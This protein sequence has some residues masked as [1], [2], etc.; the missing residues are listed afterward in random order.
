M[1]KVGEDQ[2]TGTPKVSTGGA[3]LA[4]THGNYNVPHVR[5]FFWVQEGRQLLPSGHRVPILVS[6]P[7]TPLVPS[8]HLLVGL[9]VL[10][11]MKFFTWERGELG[12]LRLH[13]GNTRRLRKRTKSSNLG[14]KGEW[15]VKAGGPPPN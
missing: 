9:R 6:H 10:H 7:E 1:G 13:G 2:V 5:E 4:L 12:E 8:H 14:G 15:R 11:V 3:G